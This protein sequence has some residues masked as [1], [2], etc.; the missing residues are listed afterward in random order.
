MKDSLKAT[1]PFILRITT[2]FGGTLQ[3]ETGGLDL[4]NTWALTMELPTSKRIANA[5]IAQGLLRK[6]EKI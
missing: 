4:A 1:D 2:A 6:V 5:L 3:Q